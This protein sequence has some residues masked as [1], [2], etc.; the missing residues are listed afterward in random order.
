LNDGSF[1]DFYQVTVTTAGTYIFT[2]T[3]SAFDSYLWLLSPR[4]GIVAISDDISNSDVNSQIKV[5]MPA[6]SFILGANSLNGNATGSYVLNSAASSAEIT[7]CEDVFVTA[8]SNTAQSLQTSDCNTTGIYADEYLIFLEP[9]QAVTASMS[10][11]AVDS[12][13][14]IFAAGTATILASNDNIDGATQ[15][16]RLSFTP[17]STA[18]SGFYIIRAR[19]TASGV[20]G[21]YTLAIQ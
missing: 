11:N 17:A 1:I 9:G 14:E 13:L 5:V 12:Y 19:S 2:Q 4:F 16:A 3:S 7:N 6:G 8:G 21:A 18:P 15:N 10:S 20:T